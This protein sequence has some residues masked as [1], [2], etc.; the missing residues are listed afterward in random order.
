MKAL[1]A[2]KHVLL[3]KP[4]AD[5]AEETREMFKLA[6]SKGLIL[7]EAFHYRFHPAVQRLKAIVDG[8]ELG[9]VKHISTSLTVPKCIM[10]PGDIRYEY[11]LGGGALMDMGCGYFFLYRFNFLMLCQ[12]TP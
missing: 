8:G 1:A 6:E 12:A 10:R 5:T 4:A 7:M 9:A 11:E 2:G 3:E